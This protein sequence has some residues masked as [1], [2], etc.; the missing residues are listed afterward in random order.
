M[1]AFLNKMR[2]LFNSA[3]YL[4]NFE[5]DSN[6]RYILESVKK[7]EPAVY[8]SFSAMYHL[9]CRASESIDRSLWSVNPDNSYTLQPLKNNDVRQFNSFEV[10]FEFQLYIEG[11]N[12]PGYNVNYERLRYLFKMFSIYPRIWVGKKESTCHLFRH[13]YVKKLMSQ[14]LSNEEIRVKLGEKNMKSALSYIES[15]FRV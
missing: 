7:I 12:E 13:N 9:G 1:P 14:G 8:P 5:L 4:E 6:L 11:I 10:P 2:V 3:Q 15:Q